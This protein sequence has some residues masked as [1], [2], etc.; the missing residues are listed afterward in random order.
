MFLSLSLSGCPLPKIPPDKARQSSTFDTNR[1]VWLTVHFDQRVLT[2]NNQ[3]GVPSF[4]AILGRTW[5]GF[6]LGTHSTTL[7][8]P[9]QFFFKSLNTS[10]APSF[11]LSLLPFSSAPTLLLSTV[12]LPHSPRVPSLHNS[13][14]LSPHLRVPVNLPPGF[15][16]FPLCSGHYSVSPAWIS[17]MKQETSPHN[18]SKEN[19]GK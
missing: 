10:P 8:I 18:R 19:R 5:K 14:R 16:S 2:R 11:S 13:S 9:L 4:T 6:Q 17:P 3:K 1:N 7:Q 15:F 12:T